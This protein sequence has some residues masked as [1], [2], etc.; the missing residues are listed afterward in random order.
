VLFLVGMLG[1]AVTLP[2]DRMGIVAAVAIT[3]VVF[4]IVFW[5]GYRIQPLYR[6]PGF[7]SIAYMNLGM[8]LTTLWLW[9]RG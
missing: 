8:L 2:I 6:A 7:S 3:F 9:L 1:L 4:R 5:V